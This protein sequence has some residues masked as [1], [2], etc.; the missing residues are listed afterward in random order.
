MGNCLYQRELPVTMLMGHNKFTR[1]KVGT[2]H[3][4][5]CLLKM[6]K[7]ICSFLSINLGEGGGDDHQPTY[8]I[9]NCHSKH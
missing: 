1:I 9:H 3:L 2:N 4:P 7:A 6:T 5:Q 8:V